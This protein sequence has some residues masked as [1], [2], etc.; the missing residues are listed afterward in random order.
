MFIEQ[1]TDIV[2]EVSEERVYAPW[3]LVLLISSTAEG[4]CHGCSRAE[5]TRVAREC[6]CWAVVAIQEW[7]ALL[8]RGSG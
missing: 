2:V 6:Q 4:C 1:A 8:N 7:T 5:S 3:R